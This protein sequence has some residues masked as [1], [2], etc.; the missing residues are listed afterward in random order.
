[1][2]RVVLDL[3]HWEPNGPFLKPLMTLEEKQAPYTSHWFD[4]TRFEQL[5]AGFPANV[6]SSLQLEREGPI[7]VADGTVISSTF[8]MLEYLAESVPGPSLTPE[9]AY[10]RYRARTWGQVLGLTLGPATSALGCARHLAPALA[11]RDARELR[12]RLGHV[13]PQERRLA[14]LAVIDGTYDAAAQ[15]VFRERLKVPVGRVE[16]ALSRSA[17]LAGPAYSIADIDAYALIDPLRELAPGVVN[18]GATPRILE[19]LERIS[20]RPA[21]RAARATGRATDPRTAFVPGVEPSRWG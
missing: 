11:R 9:S 16:A 4:P 8:F 19:W 18:A 10:D 15:D 1:M 2:S 14:W 6:E 17:W 13:E 5:E 20:A 7:L 21:T 3:Y 12:A